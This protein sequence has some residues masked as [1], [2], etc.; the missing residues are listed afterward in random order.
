MPH[1]HLLEFRSHVLYNQSVSLLNEDYAFYAYDQIHSNFDRLVRVC[2]TMRDL[3]GRSHISLGPFLLLMQRQGT[4]AFWSL[5]SNQSYEAWVLARPMLEAC[6]II[7]KWIDDGANAEIWKNR[8][9]DRRA[10]Q[11]AYQGRKLESRSLP[12][13][14]ELRRVLSRIND[15]FMHLNNRYYRRHTELLPDSGDSV[16]IQ[17]HYFDPDEVDHLTH[18]FAFLH[19]V[20]VAQ[21]SIARLWQKVFGEDGRVEIGL[22]AFESG[23]SERVTQFLRTNP[24]RRDVLEEL[25]LW[26]FE[27]AA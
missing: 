21:D 6:L 23:F 7:G 16:Y 2:S 22:E 26:S 20:L 3:N 27:E 5:A 14:P 25:G 12:R 18:V 19:L 13:S 9:T 11:K 15:D 4:T 17:V 1:S 10:Y 24:D 8:E